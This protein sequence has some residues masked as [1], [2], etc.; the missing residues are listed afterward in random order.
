M[1]KHKIPWSNVTTF[2]CA[3]ASIDFENPPLL[4]FFLSHLLF[5]SH[6]HTVSGKRNDEVNK[7]VDTACQFLIQNSRTNRQL[8][9]QPKENA[10]FTIDVE[11][12]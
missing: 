3:N 4:Q 6:V 5:G 2:G 7:T 9:Y 1:V 8:K 10:T 11:T 12:I